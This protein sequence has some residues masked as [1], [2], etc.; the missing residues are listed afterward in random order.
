MISSQI[1]GYMDKASWIRRMFEAGA[2]LKV[3]FGADAVCDFSLG[4]PDLP[5]PPAIKQTMAELAQGADQPFAFGYM[6]NAGYIETRQ[7][8]AEMVRREQGAP[9]EAGDV[10]MTCGAAGAINAFFRAVLDPGDEVVCVAPYFVEYGFYAQNYGGQLKPVRALPHT[11]DLDLPAM[12]EAIGPRTRV[13]LINSPNNPSGAVYPREDIEAL[14]DMLAQAS[15]KYGRPIF[16]A[17][18]EPYR[19]LTFEAVEVP[20]V[21]DIYPYS[22]SL[23]SFSKSLGLAGER[24]GYIA[25]A[26]DMP[27]KNLLVQGLVLTNR[28]LGYVNAP[29]IGQKLVAAARNNQVDTAVYAR[30]RQA[31]SNMLTSAGYNFTPPRGAFYFFPQVPE[32]FNGDDVA[33]V[34]RLLAEKVLAVPGSGFGYPGFFRLTFC[35]EENIITRALQG[36]AKAARA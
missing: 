1:K 11:F 21:L 20:S 8:V 13:V 32:V 4:N 33:F 17:A 3:R 28:I 5:P 30:R 36:F 16:L 23:N 7:A 26:P 27:K 19:F 18:D 12:A 2:E 24:I 29:A 15:E 31:M 10:I 25:V 34:S 6:S 35:V 9:V 14:A 22:V